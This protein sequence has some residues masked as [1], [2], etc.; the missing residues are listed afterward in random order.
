MATSAPGVG[1]H[2]TTRPWSIGHYA[3]HGCIRML[4]EQI[5]ALFPQVEVGTPVLITYKPIKLAFTTDQRVFLE[6]HPDV[7]RKV[8]NLKTAAEALIRKHLFADLVDWNKVARVVKAREGVAEEITRT[9]DTEPLMGQTQRPG[10]P[11]TN[12]VS[13]APG[14]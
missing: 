11:L 13:A 2:A 8:P 9:S 5:E 3:S 14:T 12:A 7:Y 10:A 4:P 1:I 6:V